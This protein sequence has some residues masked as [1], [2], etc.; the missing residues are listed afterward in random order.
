[1]AELGNVPYELT[2]NTLI[3]A[4]AQSENKHGKSPVA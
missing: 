2:S 3:V 4:Q 1:M